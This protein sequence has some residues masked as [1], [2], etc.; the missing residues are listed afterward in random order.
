MLG[1][2][3]GS[4]R[5]DEVVTSGCSYSVFPLWSPENANCSPVSPVV[6]L[7]TAMEF[8]VV[9]LPVQKP[10]VEFG[11]SPF[12]EGGTKSGNFPGN[13]GYLGKGGGPSFMIF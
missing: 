9:L 6:V 1:C 10:P 7:E 11:P 2:K 3:L 8:L 5:V 13:H 4:R 12:S